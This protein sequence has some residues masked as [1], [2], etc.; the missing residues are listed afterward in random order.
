MSAHTATTFWKKV[1]TNII[2]NWK[3]FA[4]GL[5]VRKNKLFEDITTLSRDSINWATHWLVREMIDRLTDN[6]DNY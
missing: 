3:S 4:F 1:R 6:E 2:I 5:S